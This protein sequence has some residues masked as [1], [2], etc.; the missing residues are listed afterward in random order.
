MRPLAPRP[1]ASG[2][3]PPQ[4]ASERP[5]PEIAASSTRPAE[6]GEVF[7]RAGLFTGLENGCDLGPLL[8]SPRAS[9][10]LSASQKS[11]KAKV[12]SELSRLWNVSMERLIVW[13]QRDSQAGLE[14]ATL[15]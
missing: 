1:F 11:Q 13:R 15:R 4:K 5:E 9:Y 10:S 14:P 6:L 7:L 12:H 8:Q 3:D 2:V